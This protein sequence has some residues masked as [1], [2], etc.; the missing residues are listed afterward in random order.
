MGGSVLQAGAAAGAAAVV[1]GR[2]QSEVECTMVLGCRYGVAGGSGCRRCMAT[3]GTTPPVQA[4][5][6]RDEGAWDSWARLTYSSCRL[7]ARRSASSTSTVLCAAMRNM[8]VHGMARAR[9]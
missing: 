9:T 3:T 1:R 2:M 5:L 8:T 4:V 6:V 7:G